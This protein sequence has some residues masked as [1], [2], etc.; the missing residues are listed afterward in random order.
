MKKL[1]MTVVIV[2]VLL[3]AGGFVIHKSKVRHDLAKARTN[4]LTGGMDHKVTV[5]AAM[6]KLTKISANW[7]SVS[8]PTGDASGNP[9]EIFQQRDRVLHS[10]RTYKFMMDG[11]NNS[12]NE[13]QPYDPEILLLEQRISKHQQA[14][15]KRFAGSG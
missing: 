14:T 1:Y 9:V 11:F 13:R 3:C 2:L 6:E 8:F 10:I 7:E 15:A 5:T 12:F 4:M